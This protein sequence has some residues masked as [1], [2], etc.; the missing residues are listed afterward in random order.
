MSPNVLER[1]RAADAALKAKD[2][3]TPQPS[4]Q[5]PASLVGRERAFAA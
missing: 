2:H 3:P 1:L 4:P 5:R